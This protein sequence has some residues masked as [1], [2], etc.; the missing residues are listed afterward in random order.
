MAKMS[1]KAGHVIFDA[2]GTPVDMANITS[3][4]A[5]ITCDTADVTAMQATGFNKEY[6]ATF[7]DW[8]ATVECVFDTDDG[9]QVAAGAGGI[10]T[11]LV[12]AF[13]RTALDAVDYAKGIWYGP[14]IC[15]GASQSVGMND[16]ITISFTFQGTGAIQ[17]A[18]TDPYA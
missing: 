17:Y 14:G 8:T 12:M 13:A 10:T 16:A 4:S 1:G 6:V 18:T 9:I 7:T 15:T 3:W 5:E 11:Y 2:D